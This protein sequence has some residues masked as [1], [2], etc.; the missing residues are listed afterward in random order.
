MPRILHIIDSLGRTGTAKQ[1]LILAEGLARQGYDVHVCAL[2]N[3]A[4]KI[5][6]PVREGSGE[7]SSELAAISFTG[8]GRRWPIDP[9]ADWQLH[10]LVKRLRPDIVQTWDCV[11]GMFGP[12]AAT[13]GRTILSVGSEKTDRIV[14]PTDPYLVAGQYRRQRWTPAWDS[15]WERRFAAHVDRCVT[16]SATVRDWC[17]RRGLPAEKFAVIPA[18]CRRP[19][20][21]T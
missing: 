11:A 12:M 20:P 21:A 9:L 13:V 6:L 8:L 10:R 7:G 1:L 16:N 19:G 17:A 2:N 4:N 14:R 3:A 18:A 15:F 5:P